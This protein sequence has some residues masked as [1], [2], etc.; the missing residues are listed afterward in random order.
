MHQHY[1]YRVHFELK[2]EFG[3]RSF[4]MRFPSYRS[5]YCFCVSIVQT[6]PE[7]LCECMVMR[8]GM[9]VNG[10]FVFAGRYEPICAG[11][12]TNKTVWKSLYVWSPQ[13]ILSLDEMRRKPWPEAEEEDL[14]RR[15]R[16]SHWCTCIVTSSE[17]ARY[18]ATGVNK[19]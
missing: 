4:D 2:G 11:A 3:N 8:E 16:N 9:K 18:F 10:S 7:G 19:L 17:G 15:E 12:L 1:G 13:H 14:P 5:C 6:C